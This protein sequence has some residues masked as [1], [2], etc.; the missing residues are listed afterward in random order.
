MLRFLGM[1]TSCHIGRCRRYCLGAVL[2]ESSQ[3]HGF[4]AAGG[5]YLS[6]LRRFAQRHTLHS[7]FGG[8]AVTNLVA[9]WLQMGGTVP[10]ALVAS[11]LV[12]TTGLAG[13]LWRR[14]MQ[15]EDRSPTWTPQRATQAKTANPR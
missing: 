2:P 10:V 5:D 1:A 12:F 9:V 4:R 15:M 13:Y 3:Q 11:G 7:A 8:P 6:N 14:L